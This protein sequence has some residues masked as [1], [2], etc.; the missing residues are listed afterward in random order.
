MSHLADGIYLVF[1]HMWKDVL[2]EAM[3]NISQ[4]AFQK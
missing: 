4:D 3:I 2:S 1:V